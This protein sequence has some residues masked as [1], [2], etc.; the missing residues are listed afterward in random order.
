MHLSR[1]QSDDRVLIHLHGSV[2]FGYSIEGS[3]LELV[4]YTNAD[5]ALA[6]LHIGVSDK[7]S[8]GNIISGT[9]IISGLDKVAKL[10]QNPVPYGY[11][12]QALTQALTQN[13]CL[14][15][16]GYGGADHT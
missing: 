15:I 4:R 3:P 16:I 13:R 8:H 6:S 7:N 5:A 10:S 14:L 1:A 2:R 9:P 12:Y 11:Y